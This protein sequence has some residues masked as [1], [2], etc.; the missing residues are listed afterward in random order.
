MLRKCEVLVD[1]EW[2]EMTFHLFGTEIVWGE[3]N[4]PHEK[5]IA[6]VEGQRGQ[7]RSVEPDHVRFLDK[8]PA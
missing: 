6:I 8:P 7:V 4:M 1:T 5:T 2:H 3:D